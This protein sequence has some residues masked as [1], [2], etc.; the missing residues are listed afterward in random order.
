MP[1]TSSTAA[2]PSRRL[3][4]K[5]PDP[6]LVQPASG[7]RGPSVDEATLARAVPIAHI[8]DALK[9]AMEGKDLDTLSLGE[10]RREV[11]TKLG[12]TEGG[13]DVRKKEIKKVV[14]DL[15]EEMRGAIVDLVKESLQRLLKEPE[16]AD[17]LQTIYAAVEI[18]CNICEGRPT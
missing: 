11:A 10:L 17:A 13:L 14:R 12:F 1:T 4:R 15:L 9:E 16:K 6:A 7:T 5:Q 18:V 3:S 8:R 2:T